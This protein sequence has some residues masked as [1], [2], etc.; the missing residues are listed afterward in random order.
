M[1]RVYSEFPQ[2]LGGWNGEYRFF[3]LSDWYQSPDAYICHLYSRVK[4]NSDD[5]KNPSSKFLI[6][7][8][9]SPPFNFI[10]GQ[11]AP[12]SRQTSTLKPNFQLLSDTSNA[13]RQVQRSIISNLDKCIQMLHHISSRNGVLD[14]IISLSSHLHTSFQVFSFSNSRFCEYLRNFS[15]SSFVCSKCF[16]ISI[17]VSR[18][19]SRHFIYWYC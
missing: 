3:H 5:P 2:K 11:V 10:Q 15:I 4:M 12:F 8:L 7:P 14:T 18:S 16:F 13:V 19:S 17:W 6:L 1:I 9:S